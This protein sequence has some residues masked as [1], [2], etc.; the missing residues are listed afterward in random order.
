MDDVHP[1]GWSRAVRFG[2]RTA[3]LI[4]KPVGGLVILYYR[5]IEVPEEFAKLD[6]AFVVTIDGRESESRRK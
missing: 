2:V 5:A 6:L 1:T 3:C 4:S